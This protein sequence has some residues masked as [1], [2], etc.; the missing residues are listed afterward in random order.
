MRTVNIHEAKTR[1]SALIE[2]AEAGK[3]VII[4]RAGRPVVRLVAI[5]AEAVQ[6]RP[7]AMRGRIRMS[8]DF[9]APLPEET[10]LSGKR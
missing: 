10:L 1:L 6:R 7:G 8:A 5:K 3:E 4:A 9:D 2:A